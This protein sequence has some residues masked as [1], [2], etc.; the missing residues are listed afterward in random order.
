MTNHTN[1]SKIIKKLKGEHF[2]CKTFYDVSMNKLDIQKS[3][4]YLKQDVED[5]LE[6]LKNKYDEQD[7]LIKQLRSKIENLELDNYKKEKKIKYYKKRRMKNG[8]MSKM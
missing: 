4:I 7:N 8:S 2:Y 6:K 1:Y 3:E 5:M